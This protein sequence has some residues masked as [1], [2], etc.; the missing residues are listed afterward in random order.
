MNAERRAY[1]SDTAVK[2]HVEDGVDQVPRPLLGEQ[3]TRIAAD[4]VEDDVQQVLVH[5]FF[6]GGV[7]ALKTAL[8]QRIRDGV[9][10][11]NRVD[12]LRVIGRRSNDILGHKSVQNELVDGR[13]RHQRE[14][15]PILHTEDTHGTES[16]GFSPNRGRDRSTP[17]DPLLPSR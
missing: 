11:G 14:F 4:A 10:H 16:R 15:R 13:Q 9:D 2:C 12:S 6:R 17:W 3:H 5:G 7:R 8:T 1:G